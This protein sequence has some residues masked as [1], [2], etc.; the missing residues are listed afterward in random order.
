MDK[1]LSPIKSRIIQIIDFKAIEKGRFLESIGVSASNFRGQSLYSEAGGEVVA[2]ILA[3]F[4]DVSAEW[5]LLGKGDM[6]RRENF[7]VNDS[8]DNHGIPL[9]PFEAYAGSGDSS[10]S[11]VDLSQVETRYVIPLYN[12]TGVD[13]MIT[14]HGSSMTPNFN[15]GDVVACKIIAELPYVVWNNVYIFDTVNDGVMIK[16]LLPGEDESNY[17]CRSDNPEY[18][19]FL[20]PKTDIRKIASVVGAVKLV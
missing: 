1:I 19:D 16:R 5:L 10:V 13:F 9:V 3:H 11:G 4:P 18:K 17:T 6:L 12:G 15:S 8:A 14:V 2:K 20:L 7:V